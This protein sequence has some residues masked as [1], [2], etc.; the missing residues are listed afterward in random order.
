MRANNSRFGQHPKTSKAFGVPDHRVRAAA[1]YFHSLLAAVT[2]SDL[3]DD[4]GIDS[5]GLQAIEAKAPA[6]MADKGSG[7]LGLVVDHDG[8]PPAWHLSALQQQ[9]IS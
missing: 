5:V 1:A 7:Q 9:I 8:R 3:C 4:L 2:L 6:P